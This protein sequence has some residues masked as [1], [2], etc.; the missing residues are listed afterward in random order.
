MFPRSHQRMA[1]KNP[2]QETTTAIEQAIAANKSLQSRLLAKLEEIS[3]TKRRNRLQCI[4]I[5]TALE[6]HL[7]DEANKDFGNDQLEFKMPNIGKSQKCRAWGN[8]DRKW[9]RHYFIDPDNS[10]PEPNADEIERRKWEGELAS[11]SYVHRFTPWWKDEMSLLTKFAEEVRKEQHQQLQ[12][13]DEGDDPVIVKDGDIDFCEVAKRVQK[14]LAKK[15]FTSAQ[16]STFHLHNYS[17]AEGTIRKKYTPR[18][19]IDH[20]IKFLN[21]LSPS[22]NKRPFTKEET[23]KIMEALHLHHGNPNWATLAQHLNTSRTPFQIFRH[24]QTKL[25]NTLRDLSDPSILSKDEDELLLKYIAASGPQMVINNHANI[26]LTRRFFPQASAIQMSTRINQS[27]VNPQFVN[28]KWTEEEERMV[29]MGMKVYQGEYAA[30]KA[31]FL[32][33]SRSSKMVCDKWN[34]SLNPCYNTQPFSQIEDRAMIA[35]VK[36]RKG[37]IN[38]WSEITSKFPLRHP[39][40]VKNRWMELAKREDI[41]KLQGNQYMRWGMQRLGRKI[42]KSRRNEDGDTADLDVLASSDFAVRFKKKLR[43]SSETL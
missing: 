18:P 11:G 39:A 30:P 43:T 34:R 25:S 41:V 40:A 29:V 35:A 7:E 4:Q 10:I 20:R 15:L 23:L 14:E 8:L 42:K 12:E 21:S 16:R 38:S 17:L 33:D 37:I 31:A 19:W 27:L 24:A 22:I 3:D 28:E 5:N 32:V 26:V 2:L 36:K 6:N 13:N 1:T 9:K